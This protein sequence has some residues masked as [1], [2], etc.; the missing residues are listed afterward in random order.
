VDQFQ[1]D[2]FGGHLNTSANYIIKPDNRAIIQM[3][4]NITRMDIKK[5]LEDFND[6]EKFYEP[7]IRSENLS[8]LL[9]CDFYTRA[10]V[11]GD[12]LDQDALRVKGDFQLEEGG[13]YNFEPAT[14]LSEK[15]NINELDNIQFKNLNSQ[16]F[17]MKGAIY[18]PQTYISST[19]LDITA[20]GMQEFGTDYEYHLKLHL[21][22][23]LVGKSDKLLKEQAKRGD[24]AEKDERNNAVYMM[25]YSEDGKAKTGFDKKK[26]QSAMK[27][28]IRLQ[29]AL[30]KVRFHPEMFK[31]ETGVYSE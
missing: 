26:F 16:V 1:F 7:S 9:T 4:N 11:L 31:F 13:V 30:L 22:D 10:D 14:A 6:F 17:I 28:K 20:Y 21:S 2:A 27:T 18:V 15:T 24:I 12:S 3:K 25:A 8:G 23:I 29:E 5:L 19:A